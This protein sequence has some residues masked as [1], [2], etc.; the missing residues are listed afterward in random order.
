MRPLCLLIISLCT[1]VQHVAAQQPDSWS[2]LDE[3]GTNL[4][5]EQKYDE[6]VKVFLQALDAARNEFGTSHANFAGTLKS[7]AIL[8]YYLQQAEESEKYFKE[9]LEAYERISGK[10]TA[11]YEDTLHG[12]TYLY[13]A[14][15]EQD[16]LLAV[17][18]VQMNV[19]A[20]VHGKSSE[21]HLTV[22]KQIANLLMDRKDFAKAESVLEAG[23]SASS[24]ATPAL[25][26]DFCALLFQL[27]AEQNLADKAEPYYREA[28][29]IRNN[30]QREFWKTIDFKSMTYQYEV[31]DPEARLAYWEQQVK[32][33]R[34][35]DPES[36]NFARTLINLATVYQSQE[37][38]KKAE[39][40]LMEAK[41]IIEENGSVADMGTISGS[42]GYFYDEMGNQEMSSKNYG[43]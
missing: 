30:I 31:D 10:F 6:S 13:S 40:L 2:K 41:R 4:F 38:L 12:L 15:G 36:V 33:Q 1:F 37:E 19:A 35:S 39:S 42:L 22:Q 23:Y 43:C 29:T 17:T 7:V 14:T 25:R 5:N 20:E 24:E 9:S 18:E 32:A 21:E 11:D 26:G 16:K 8:Y 34:E 28:K 3:Q 27:Y